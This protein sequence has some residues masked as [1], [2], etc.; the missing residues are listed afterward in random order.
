MASRHDGDEGVRSGD[1]VHGEIAVEERGS[2]E[3]TARTYSYDPRRYLFDVQITGTVGALA[4]VASAVMVATGFLAFFGAIALVL[5]LYTAF[6]T[7]VAKCYPRVASLDE[8]RL[9][10][11]SFGRCDEYRIADIHRIQLRENG[12]TLSVYVRF[13]GGGVLRGRYFI[14]CG[15]MYDEEGRRAQVLYDALLDLQA[16]LDPENIRVIARKQAMRVAAR[17]EAEAGEPKP[18]SRRHNRKKRRA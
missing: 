16:R 8:E 3:G 4:A 14:G 13:N 11:E 5:G 15:D 18:V 6:N 7:F 2:D 1:V 9:V 17:A 10:L 12:K